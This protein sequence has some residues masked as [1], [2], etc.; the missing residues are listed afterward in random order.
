MK[1]KLFKKII[2]FT[3]GGLIGVS[4]FIVTTP[5]QEAPRGFTEITK[6][7][8]LFY[9]PYFDAASFTSSIK[10]MQDA[11][12]L[13][14]KN[15]IANL[16]KIDAGYARDYIDLINAH[17][18]FP[19]DFL[20]QLPDLSKTT[21][22]FYK[23]P[24]H[25][26][27]K[28]LLRDYEQILDSYTQYINN[29]RDVL[30]EIDSHIPDDRPV[31][32]FFVESGTSLN[33]AQYDFELMH[34]NSIALEEAITYRKNCLEGKND[35]IQQKLY[36]NDFTATLVTD[37][38]NEI[39][40]DAL[41]F[42][43][44][45]RK[46]SGPYEITSS[47]WDDDTPIPFYNITT[48]DYGNHMMMPKRADRN[49]YRLVSPKATDPINR[50]L[51][52]RNLE[53]YFQPEATT[54]EC[55]DLTFY[56]ELLVQDFIYTKPDT[57]LDLISRNAFGIMAPAFESLAYYTNLLARSQQI[58]DIPVISPQFLFITRSA[59]SL[60]YLPF[61]SSVW[62]IDE[63]PEYMFTQEIYNRIK[64]PDQFIT[65]QQLLS[66]GWLQAD[67]KKAHLNQDELINSLIKN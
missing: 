49:Y 56:S 31:Y 67:I 3:I 61:A 1:N 13:L 58:K 33:I 54:Y 15:I 60:T 32:Y 27:A 11:E 14:K 17:P 29:M 62:R 38:K 16:S 42:N 53:F 40:M 10:N 55:S 50:T 30:T 9:A 45:A 46:I 34:K 52:E 22:K 41:P 28:K 4:I 5:H 25:Q 43:E 59:Y 20:K 21:E 65:S 19:I 7:D 26:N 37:P 2:L 36:E 6:N 12:K 18:L 23:T 8:P 47:C 44:V 64:G 35:C 24:T 63:T 66:D 51:Q 39:V 57:E 48:T